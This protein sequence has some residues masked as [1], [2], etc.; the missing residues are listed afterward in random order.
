MAED[1]FP[2]KIGLSDKC[3]NDLER[4]AALAD[5]E[6]WLNALDVGIEMVKEGAKAHAKGKTG[7]V[8]CTPELESS[9]ENNPAFFE[10]LCQEGVIEWLTPFVLGKST[11]LPEGKCT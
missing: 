3:K 10:A 2:H 5:L 8:F 1:K 9:I 7:C 11:L 6:G 4:A